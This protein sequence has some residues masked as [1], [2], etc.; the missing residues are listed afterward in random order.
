MPVF[1]KIVKKTCTQPGCPNKGQ[2]VD[3]SLNVCEFDGTPLVPEKAL[4]TKAVAFAGVTAL[5]FLFIAGYGATIAVK[6]WLITRATSAVVSQLADVYD[7]SFGEQLREK[8]AGLVQ[9]RGS[10]PES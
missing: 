6:R 8:A 9:I 3:L 1:Q 10:D 4:D 2:P 5:F 7:S